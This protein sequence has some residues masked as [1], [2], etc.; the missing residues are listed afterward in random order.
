MGTER[1]E[2]LTFSCKEA[3]VYIAPPA[4]TVGHRAELWDVDNPLQARFPVSLVE[5]IQVK[6]F[7]GSYHDC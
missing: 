1:V 6:E 7:R 3:Y 2:L 4:T 5:F